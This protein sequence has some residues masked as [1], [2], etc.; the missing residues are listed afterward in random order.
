[1]KKFL[2]LM[3]GICLIIPCAFMFS[4]CKKETKPEAKIETW[5]G[6]IT[7]VS[8]VDADD[9]GI[10]LIDTAEKLAGFAAAVND[11]ESFEGFLWESGTLIPLTGKIVPAAQ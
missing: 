7:E 2:T 6:T 10:I 8:V 3:L 5:D 4:G 9:E 11:G 1:M